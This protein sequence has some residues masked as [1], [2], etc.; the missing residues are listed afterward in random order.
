MVNGKAEGKGTVVYDGKDKYV[1]DFKD[2]MKHGKGK[3]FDT[4]RLLY[5]NGDWREG[6][7]H[8]NGT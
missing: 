3:Y 7:P 5:Y 8:G 4:E 2:D 1:G 6:L